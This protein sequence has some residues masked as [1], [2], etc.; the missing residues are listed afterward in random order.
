MFRLVSHTTFLLAFSMVAASP[1]R[2]QDRPMSLAEQATT[3]TF[4]SDDN[5]NRP[6]LKIGVAL[7]GGGALGVAHIGV[8]RWFRDH[9]I[10]IDYIAGTSMGGL[11]AG[12]Y[13]TGKTPQELEELV[14]EQNWDVIIGGQTS[15]RDLSY[16]RKQDARDFQN[17]LVLGLKHGLSAPSGLN[18]GRDISLLIDRQTLAYSYL[19]SFDDLPISFRCVATE[20]V[21]GKAAVFSNGSLQQALRATMSIPG[22]FS[23]VRDDGKV[24]VDG[25]L[26][27]NLPTDVVRSMGADIVIAVHLAV[28]SPKPE[29]LQSLF[30]VLGDSV[31]VAI[32]ESELRGLANADLVVNVDLHDYSSLDYGKAEV[33]I[34]LGEKAA[35]QKR[36]VLSVYSLEN[37]AWQNYLEIQHA[38]ERKSVPIPHFLRVEG[39]DPQSAQHL[40]TFLRPLLG[41]PIDPVV[42]DHLLTR[43]TG[44]GKYD[45]ADYRLATRAGQSGLIITVHEMNNAP[46][47]LRLG[48][49]VDGAESNDVTFTLLSRLTFMDVAGFRSEWRTTLEFGNTYG[50]QSELYKPL[51]PTTRWF[52]APRGGATDTAF[53]IYSKSNPV[54]EYRIEQAD[55]GG[56]LG[57]AINHFSE[58]RMGYE[59]GYRSAYLRLGEPQFGSYSGRFGDAQLHFL[60]DHRDDPVVPRSGS[61][62]EGI[63]RWYDANPGATT[64][65]PLIQA[66]ADYYHPVSERGSVFAGGEGG[67]SFGYANIGV[68]QFFLG[69]P[70]RLSAYGT[71]ELFGNQYYD[72][73][74]GYLRNL[75]TLPPFVGKSVYATA[76]YEFAKMYNFPNESNFPNDV[77]AGVIAQTVAGPLF[78]GASFGD[79][80]HKK[81]FFQLG[82]IF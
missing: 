65:F 2:G 24:Y 19:E 51:N 6:R 14:K 29:E 75:L 59:V 77:A 21:S 27:D 68:P 66:R 44:L 61:R 47:T 40:E 3:P 82:H 53:K 23:P 33:M 76:S 8:L 37:V 34:G 5:S 67:S 79:T 62:V 55:L 18:A 36:N 46:P 69:G 9:H 12:F 81:W 45:S 31:D 52:V 70:G 80:G 54:A 43:L 28:A 22:L 42:L 30:S 13:A 48:F 35:E 41:K 72:I 56:D 4:P 50:V 26:V 16:R 58:L 39:T 17:S 25:G 15:Y 78:V 7:E 1:S 20:V 71:N 74:F 10:P 73:Q 32:R 64:S 60:S 57:C 49:D 11:V 63:F 38:R